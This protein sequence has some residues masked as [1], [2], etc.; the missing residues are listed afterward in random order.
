LKISEPK[1]DVEVKA[2]KSKGEEALWKEDHIK[3]NKELMHEVLLAS[4]NIPLCSFI[5]SF[6]EC[7]IS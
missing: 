4:I 2:G 1:T 5:D 3:R 7:Q 6:I